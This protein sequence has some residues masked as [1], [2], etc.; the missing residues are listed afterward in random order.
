MTPTASYRI[1][2]C[3]PRFVSTIA[4]AL[5]LSALALPA[6]AQG[7]PRDTGL[8]TGTASPLQA[9]LD[10]LERSRYAD[11]REHLQKATR[12]AGSQ[13]AWLGL[14]RLAL[15]EGKY[16][17]ALSAARQAERS[18][19]RARL[20]AAVLTAR[21]LARQGKM[22][23]AIAA[24]RKVESD[25]EARLARV[26]L[27]ELL[28]LT[29][30]AAGA[31]TPLMTLVRDYN[32]DKINERDGDGLALVGRA[33][34]LMRSAADANDAYNESEKTGKKSAQTLLWRAVSREVRH[35][36]CGGGACGAAQSGAGPPGRARAH[37]ARQAGPGV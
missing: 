21:A 15:L 8:L 26:I 27:G 20:E 18:G 29:G 14:G 5:S 32:D 30:D 25:P 9:G 2:R 24:V 28:V 13:D 4:M 35:R 12:G 10:A 23:E 1:R 17:E 16:D 11:A 6:F 34:H 19:G 3:L 37:G 7:A 36:P 31:R 33:A 22:Q